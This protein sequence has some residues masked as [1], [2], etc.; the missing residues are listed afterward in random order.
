MF[1]RIVTDHRICHGKACI[2]GTRVMVSTLVDCVA[3]GMTFAEIRAS[4]PSVTDKDIQAALSYAAALA[5]ES[6]FPYL[7][8]L[9]K[10]I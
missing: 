1:K 9:K 6:V 4:F 5:R 10:A 7:Q 3:G 2:K 8:G